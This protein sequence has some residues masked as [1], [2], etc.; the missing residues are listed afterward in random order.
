MIVNRASAAPA[1]IRITA[2]AGSRTNTVTANTNPQVLARA[3]CFANGT[4]A[5][6]SRWRQATYVTYSP[7]TPPIAAMALIKTA[8]AVVI[9]FKS[10][11]IL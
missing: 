2:T 10:I 8:I 4:A 1:G 6:C 5:G 7:T 3:D 9:L 11:I